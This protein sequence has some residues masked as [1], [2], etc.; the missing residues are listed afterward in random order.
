MEDVLTLDERKILKELRRI[1]WREVI[2]FGQVVVQIREGEPKTVS[3]QKT[4]QYP[5]EG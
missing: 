5:K 2:T 4:V 3:L 1:N